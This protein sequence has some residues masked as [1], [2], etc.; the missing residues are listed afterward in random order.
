MAF[1]QFATTLSVTAAVAVLSAHA[2]P[3]AAAARS[4]PEPQLQAVTAR[5]LSCWQPDLAAWASVAPPHQVTVN[6]EFDQSGVPRHVHLDSADEQRF[7]TDPLFQRVSL[8]ALTAAASCRIGDLGL[9]RNAYSVWQGI[10]FTYDPAQWHP[11]AQRQ[12]GPPPA[13]PESQIGHGMG[14]IDVIH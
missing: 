6:I 14:V 1:N 2:W 11:P 4:L 8:G 5:L 10:S 7:R 3:A 12:A 13:S 9:P